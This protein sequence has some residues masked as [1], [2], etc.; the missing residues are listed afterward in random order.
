M[1]ITDRAQLHA[2]DVIRSAGQA[3]LG[4][5]ALWDAI[6]DHPEHGS[7]RSTLHRRLPRRAAYGYVVRVGRGSGQVACVASG[8]YRA[9]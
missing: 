3:G 8:F 1:K 4:V 6:K 5:T 2:L 7:D 9:A